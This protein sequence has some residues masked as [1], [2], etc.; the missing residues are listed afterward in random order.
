MRSRIPWWPVLVCLLLLAPLPP[1]T[2]EAA[3]LYPCKPVAQP[4]G[5]CDA[6]CQQEIGS[7]LLQLHAGLQGDEQRR[8]WHN[9]SALGLCRF[10]CH[11]VPP[12][13]GWPGVQCC[14]TSNDSRA[15]DSSSGCRSTHVE[16]ELCPAG[17]PPGAVLKL[18]LTMQ[19]LGGSLTDRVVDALKTLT[20]WGLHAIDFSRCAGSKAAGSSRLAG[21]AAREQ[22][23]SFGR[24]AMPTTATQAPLWWS[25]G[26][27]ACLPAPPNQRRALF[28]SSVPVLMLHVCSNH[29]AGTIP[30]RLSELGPNFTT[31]NLNF[32]SECAGCSS[33]R[34]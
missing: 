5:G 29:L 14:H 26:A 18:D 17:T 10:H 20:G 24:C 16:H 15:H 32:N 25:L 33:D 2:A 34:P 27:A 22:A 19:K 21:A 28:E 23:H 31:I 8:P 4:P 30:E 7:A 6:A 1:P 3:P 11:S 13:C 12:Y 9:E